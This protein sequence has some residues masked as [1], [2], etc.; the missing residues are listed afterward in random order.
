MVLHPVVTEGF[1]KSPDDYEFGRPGYNKDVVDYLSQ[2]FHLANGSQIVDLAT[3]TG[4]FARA[5]ASS[6]A[7]VIGI[8]PVEGM[9]GKFRELLPSLEIVGGIAEAL[10]LADSSVDLITVAQAFH[11]FEGD[12]AIQEIHRVLRKGGG[13]ALVY[14]V[15][16]STIPWVGKVNK[17]VDQY[18]FEGTI[19]RHKSGKWKAAFERTTN[20]F[21]PLEEAQFHSVQRG[22]EELIIKRFTSVSYIAALPERKKMEF[23]N[24]VRTILHTDPGTAGMEVIELPY[25]VDVYWCIKI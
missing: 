20:L 11:W 3:G 17:L 6:G 25:R 22:N 9:R 14:N 24:K 4:K 13:L 16:D 1:Q 12:S 5:I 2:V 18:E 7:Q 15:R 21:T 8:D 19:P 23:E 10:P